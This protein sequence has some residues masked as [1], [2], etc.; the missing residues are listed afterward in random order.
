LLLSQFGI[1]IHGWQQVPVSLNQAC[2]GCT[3]DDIVVETIKDCLLGEIRV[4]YKL[5]LGNCFLFHQALQFDDKSRI[6]RQH[7]SDLFHRGSGPAWFF[8]ISVTPS[9]SVDG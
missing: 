6:L 8:S 1:R 9:L 4:F 3:E 7:C 5:T 2:S